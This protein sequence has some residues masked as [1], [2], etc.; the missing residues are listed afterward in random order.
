MN[1]AAAIA[2]SLSLP[3]LLAACTATVSNQTETDAS[4]SMTG[5]LSSEDTTVGTGSG[6]TILDDESSDTSAMDENGMYEDANDN[7]RD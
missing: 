3:L 4:S 7:A 1:K 2:I 5:E 6:S